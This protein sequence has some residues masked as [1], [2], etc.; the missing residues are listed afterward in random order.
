MSTHNI[1]FMENSNE[2]P[3]HMFFWRIVENY[4]LIIIKYLPLSDLLLTVASV[5]TR[6]DVDGQVYKWTY[7]TPNQSSRCHENEWDVIVSCDSIKQNLI[8]AFQI[9]HKN[10]KNLDNRK[11]CDNHP[12]T[13]TRCFTIEYYI[14]KY[15]WNGTQSDLGLHYLPRSVCPKT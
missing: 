9:Y 15:R 2:Y 4:P 1:C 13:R 10:P 6:V 8:K 5:G 3:Q 7:I 12:K 11:I 14:Q